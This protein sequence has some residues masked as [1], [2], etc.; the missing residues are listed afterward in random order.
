ML[1]FMETIKL[2]VNHSGLY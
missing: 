1:K 2:V